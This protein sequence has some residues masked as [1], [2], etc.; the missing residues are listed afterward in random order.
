[1]CGS[2]DSLNGQANVLVFYADVGTKSAMDRLGH[3]F[4]LGAQISSGFAF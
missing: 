4:D 3:G 1:V 2:N